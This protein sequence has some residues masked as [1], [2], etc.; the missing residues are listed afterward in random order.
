MG[1][2]LTKSTRFPFSFFSGFINLYLGLSNHLGFKY[3]QLEK[4]D[5][6]MA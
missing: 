6:T 4:R 1:W 5:F 2:D 3:L